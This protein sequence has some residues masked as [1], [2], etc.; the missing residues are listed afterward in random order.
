MN[1]YQQIYVEKVT[2][3]MGIG[4]PGE[5]L[6]KSLRLLSNLTHAKPVAT[7]TKKRIPT[8]SLRP[9]LSIGCKVTLR[10]LKA[11]DFLKKLLAARNNLLKEQNFDDSGNFSFGIPEYLDIP[12]AEYD[13]QL[14]IVGLETAVTL[15]RPGFRI[16]IR[17]IHKRKIPSRHRITKEEAVE[18]I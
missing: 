16:K 4:A 2:L 3:N 15:V 10:G 13:M 8:W 9:G 12:G 6:E 7:F 18:F 11:H 17:H 5:K 14:G 1:R